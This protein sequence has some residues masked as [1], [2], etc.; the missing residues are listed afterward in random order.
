M[1]TTSRATDDRQPSSIKQRLGQIGIW[2]G[3]LRQ[4]DPVLVAEAAAELDELGFGGLWIPGATGGDLLTDVSRLLAA[5]RK[6]TIATGILNIWKHDAHDVGVWWHTLST[7]HQARF[8]LGLGVSHGAIIGQA[9]GKPLAAM[10]DYLAHLSQDK[11][12]ASSICLAALGPKMLELA[13]DRTAGAHPYL[14]TPEHTASARKTLGPTPLLAPEQGVVLET[15]PARARDIARPYVLGY[16]ALANYAN[17][18]MRLG[19]TKADI[20][21]GSDR[22]IDALFAWGG[23]DKIAERVKAHLNA[24][25][26]HVCLQVA[27][28]SSAPDF[29]ATRAAWRE[30][31]AALL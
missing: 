23:A 5:T 4:V 3:E 12:P 24:G 17:N 15:D 7:E 9:Y 29:N 16:G 6:A 2:S 1:N 20:A 22:L 30:L 27:G 28:H 11:I 31:A 26:D 14:V 18:W 25:A 19:F 21:T 10:N 13:R 8:L